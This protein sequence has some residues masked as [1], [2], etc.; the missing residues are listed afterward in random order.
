MAWQARYPSQCQAE[1]GRGRHHDILWRTA[2][3]SADCGS[4]WNRKD[5]HTGSGHQGNTEAGGDASAHLYLLQQV[6][7]GMSCCSGSSRAS[8]LQC[9]QK[10]VTFVGLSVVSQEGALTH[11]GKQWLILFHYRQIHF[12]SAVVPLLRDH[13]SGETWPVHS[14]VV[15]PLWVPTIG[16]LNR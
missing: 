8:T 16:S 7:A 1:G 4:I 14:I 11:Q 10:V 12:N 5:L 2:A 15:C 13:S 3:P 6:S 9:D